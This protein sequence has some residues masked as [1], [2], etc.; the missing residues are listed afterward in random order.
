MLLNDSER[1]VVVA[2]QLN[3]EVRQGLPLRA[4]SPERHPPATSLLLS[5]IDTENFTI[6]CE[7]LHAH[8]FFLS[9]TF[10]EI[11]WSFH[12]PTAQRLAVN[13]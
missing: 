8:K 1:S 5:T 10:A 9:L 2:L 11:I 3:G 13:C 6:L 12:N 7:H 4:L